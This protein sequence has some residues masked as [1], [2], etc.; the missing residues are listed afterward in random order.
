MIE[1]IK[2]KLHA[3]KIYIKQYK[4]RIRSANFYKKHELN[5]P[6]DYSSTNCFDYYKCIFIHIP[7]TAGLSMSKTLFGN[8]AGT[9]HEITY[10]L[11]K[12]GR[13]TVNNYFKFTFVR[14]PW[15]RL[16]SAFNYLKNGGINEIDAKFSSDHLSSI[17]NFEEFVLNWLNED[18]ILIYWHFIPQ[19]RFITTAKNR[20][21]IMVDFVGR[22][23]NLNEDFNSVC[24]ILNFQNARLLKLNESERNSD[25]SYKE[26]YTKE[27]ID[28]VSELYKL[29]IALFNYTF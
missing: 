28:K 27:M 21:L 14:N 4:R 13:K 8:Y 5:N 2:M 6:G 16:F 23:E 3:L 20:D 24:K 15:D 22:F 25:K 12:F 18:T 29:D 17:S 19:Y 11:N 1:V 26:F 10:Y 7:K 9:H